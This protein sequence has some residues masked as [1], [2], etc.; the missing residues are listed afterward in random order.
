VKKNPYPDA[1]FLLFSLLNFS[2]SAGGNTGEFLEHR[3]ASRP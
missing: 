3:A 2:L 1:E